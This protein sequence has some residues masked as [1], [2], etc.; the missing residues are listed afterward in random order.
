MDDILTGLFPVVSKSM[1]TKRGSNAV[2]I[3]LKFSNLNQKTSKGCPCPPTAQRRVGTLTIKI[4]L[5]EVQESIIDER[6]QYKG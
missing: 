3:V 6:A 5:I 4:K 2:T 1:T